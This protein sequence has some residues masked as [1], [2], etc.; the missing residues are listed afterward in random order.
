MR[1]PARIAKTLG[2]IKACWETCPDMRLGQ[3]LWALADGDPFYIE[4]DVLVEAADKLR[5]NRQ[6]GDQTPKTIAQ[7][8]AERK[9]PF[10]ETDG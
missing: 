1:D 4:E 8:E 7:I 5:R 10:D 9:I 3:L 2:A 6:A